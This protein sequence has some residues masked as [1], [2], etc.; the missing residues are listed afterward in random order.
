MCSFTR[1][2]TQEDDQHAAPSLPIREPFQ[3]DS[4]TQSPRQVEECLTFSSEVNWCYLFTSGPRGP[5]QWMQ[6]ETN[7]T[8][9]ILFK[10]VQYFFL[11]FEFISVYFLVFVSVL[12]CWRLNIFSTDASTVCDAVKQIHTL[13]G[14]SDR[15]GDGRGC[16]RRLSL[17]NCDGRTVT[18]T[19]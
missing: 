6:L 12:C 19:L 13:N 4:Q 8:H 10:T 1:N 7:Y 15:H 16:E 2:Q 9:L 11:F 18:V 17:T 5:G 3:P 14:T